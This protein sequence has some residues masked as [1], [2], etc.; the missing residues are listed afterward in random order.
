M[1]SKNTTIVALATPPIKSAIHIIRISGPD[2]YDIVNKLSSYNVTPLAHSLQYVK[3]YDGKK[4]IDEV[5]LLKYTAPHSYTGEDMIEIT[6]H[7]SVYVATNIIKKLIE[8]GAKIAKNGEFTKRAFLNNKISLV[9]ASA[10]NNIINST[11]SKSL[12]LAQKGF[13][14]K[15]SDAL[16]EI[17]HD[18]F[19]I[20]GQIE[21][22]IDYPEYDDVPNVSNKDIEK[23]IKSAYKYLNEVIDQSTKAIPIMNGINVAIVG[24]PNVGKSSLLNAI[25]NENKAIV[26]DIP[27]TT[28]DSIQ[29]SAIIDGLTYNFMDTAGI[30]QSSDKIENLGIQQTK[31]MIDKADFV[32]FIVDG[33]RSFDKDDKK[34]LELVKN[35]K[36]LIVINKNDLKQVKLPIKGISI[37]AKKKNISSLFKNIGKN[38]LDID[39]S[40]DLILPTES[41]ITEIKSCISELKTCLNCLSKKQPKDLIVEYLH[42]AHSNIL[43]VLGESGDYNFINDLFDNFCVGK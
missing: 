12:S 28:R 40:F 9:Q 10:I 24:K 3:L 38:I 5:V 17:A 29:Y 42:K 20:I 30:H 19:K 39:M 18:V 25:L 22:N 36:H 7:G 16:H 15:A 23:S 33:S 13:D 1:S 32:L 11:S 21:V 2:C 35:K 41:A 6:C 8:R 43:N 34:I 14:K 37:S 4:F 27:G 31:K 26:S